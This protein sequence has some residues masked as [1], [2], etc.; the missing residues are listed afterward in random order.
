MAESMEAY[1]YNSSVFEFGCIRQNSLVSTHFLLYD[2]RRSYQQVLKSCPI[3]ELWSFDSD[4]EFT[5]I[6]YDSQ[7]ASHKAKHNEIFALWKQQHSQK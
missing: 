3:I 1:L 2:Y 4:S 6:K 5:S 7:S